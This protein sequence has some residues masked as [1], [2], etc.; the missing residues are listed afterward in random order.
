MDLLAIGIAFFLYSVVLDWKSD[1]VFEAAI[2][3]K[4]MIITRIV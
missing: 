4:S 3:K 1:N 2:M